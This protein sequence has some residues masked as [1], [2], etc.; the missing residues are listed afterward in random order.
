MPVLKLGDA[1][2]TTD[3]P[4]NLTNVLYAKRTLLFL[5]TVF[6]AKLMSF[7][8]LLTSARQNCTRKTYE[9]II[10]IDFCDSDSSLSNICKIASD[11]TAVVALFHPRNRCAKPVTR[12]D[13]AACATRTA[14]SCLHYVSSTVLIQSQYCSVGKHPSGLYSQTSVSEPS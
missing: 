10:N 5:S 13:G 14:A 8:A 11:I 7:D 4:L 3:L 9:Q 1:Q 12:S 2:L 6:T